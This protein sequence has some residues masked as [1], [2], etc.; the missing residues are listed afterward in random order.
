VDETR[1]IA[2][3]ILKRCRLAVEPIEYLGAGAQSICYGVGKVAILI[4][5]GQVYEEGNDYPLQKWLTTEAVRAGVR[6]PQILEVGEQPRPYA[7]MQ[8]AFGAKA[9]TLACAAEKAPEWF[10][11]LGQEIRKVNRIRTEGFGPFVLTA[12][13]QYRGQHA[14]WSDYLDHHIETYLFGDESCKEGQNVRALFL[15]QGIISPRELTK[16]VA[17]V[18]AAK[19]WPVESVLTHYDN[20]LDNLIV[21]GET[22]TVLDWGL[23]FAGIGIR[24]ELIKLFEIAPTSLADP[25]VAAFLR[26]YGLTRDQAEEAVEK[27]KLMLI[28]DGLVMSYGWANDP[29]WLGGI[30][31]WLQ[32]IKGLCD[33]WE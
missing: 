26:G 2:Q 31:A 24:Q 30:R 20:R 10:G 32:T 14:A 8:R 12:N 5:Q 16:I 22:V 19:G 17:K 1:R 28:L 33:E 21:D 3:T 23:A 9:S 27:A 11:T 15:A 13:G 25:H 18:E 29:D 7:L 4:A 6:T